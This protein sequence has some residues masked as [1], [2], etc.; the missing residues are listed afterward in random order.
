[1][2]AVSP[3]RSTEVVSPD[4]G[5]SLL[6]VAEYVDKFKIQLPR[7]MMLLPQNILVWNV[8]GLNSRARHDAVREFVAHEHATVV[9]LVETKTAVLSARMAND[10]MGGVIGYVCLPAVGVVGG[11]VVAW[12][13]DAWEVL[14]SVH[15]PLFLDR[16][17]S[18]FAG[19]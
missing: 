5:G 14:A 19:A 8:R 15:H 7:A 9:C 12:R 11:I 2:S 4:Q 3:G 13:S 1:M 18:A 6:P 10:L 17:D 16:A